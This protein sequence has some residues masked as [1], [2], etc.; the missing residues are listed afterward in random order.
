MSRVLPSRQMNSIDEII[1]SIGERRFGHRRMAEVYKALDLFLSPG[2]PAQFV[3]V[4][5]PAGI[6]KT[7]LLKTILT[8]R[9]ETIDASHRGILIPAVMVRA[10][11][12]QGEDFPYVNLYEDLL[13]GLDERGVK[14]TG[15]F[16][17]QTI[18]GTI[19]STFVPTALR[20]GK[21]AMRFKNR[22]REAVRARGTGIVI[23]DE[24]SSMIT[25]AKGNAQVAGDELKTLIDEIDDARLVLSGSY[26][27]FHIK[28]VSAQLARRI[29]VVFFLPYDAADEE[30]CKEFRLIVCTLLAELP[31]EHEVVVTDAFVERVMSETFGVT[32]HW[33]RAVVD[34]SAEH[35]KLHTRFTKELLFSYLPNVLEKKVIEREI[36]IIRRLAEH[37]LDGAIRLGFA[38]FYGA[39]PRQLSPEATPK[40]AR[41]RVG[42]RKLGRD[43]RRA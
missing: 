23:I 16:I 4:I 31:F 21:V 43:Q 8:D 26:E 32:G 35:L 28:L 25:A 2:I 24:A 10:D 30:D 1:A 41:G 29:K 34:A 38:D 39:L 27:L 22:A 14:S 17:H 9:L 20:I 36:A 15:E 13:N 33:V 37:D 6:G 5:G 11:S 12:A 7:T 42:K 18:L 3:I 19:V 40:K